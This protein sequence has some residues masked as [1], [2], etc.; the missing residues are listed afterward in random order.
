MNE[1][2][3][4]L[5]ALRA[6][7]KAAEN[8]IRA[9][10]PKLRAESEEQLAFGAFIELGRVPLD[11][12]HHKTSARIKFAKI[13]IIERTYGIGKFSLLRLMREGAIRSVLI[14]AS[15][16]SRGVH[17]VDLRSLEAYLAKHATGGEIAS[18]FKDISPSSE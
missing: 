10:E 4:L 8:I 7:I 15:R 6:N 5:H 12:P 16:K 9:I 17:L 11:A 18:P 2:E 13:Q 14:K 3:H 1:I